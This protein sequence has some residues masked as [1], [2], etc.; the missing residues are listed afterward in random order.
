MKRLITT[1]ALLAAGYGVQAHVTMK[2]YPIVRL[3]YTAAGNQLVIKMLSSDKARVDVGKTAVRVE[4]Q[5]DY[6]WKGGV[7]MTISPEK[8][9]TFAVK[10]RIPGWV[11]NEVMPGRLYSYANEKPAQATL[12]LTDAATLRVTYQPDLLNGG[13]VITGTVPNKTG[14][15]AMLKANPYYAWSNRGVGAMNVWLPGPE[16]WNRIRA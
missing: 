11:R 16:Y 14:Q 9:A 12:T 6:P 4:Q 15:S 8:A 7:R 13:N 10:I 1:F 3:M 5:T 2:G